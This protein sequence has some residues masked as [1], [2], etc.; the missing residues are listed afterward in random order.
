[1]LITRNLSRRRLRVKRLS[2]KYCCR[3]RLCHLPEYRM[4]D[5][6]HESLCRTGLKYDALKELVAILPP[7]CF[8]FLRFIILKE[9]ELKIIYQFKEGI[10]LYSLRHI[11]IRKLIV[12]I[13]V[14]H[15]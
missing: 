2:M 15:V 11:R 4:H 10:V 7:D 9:N 6:K 12:F 14:R 5:E 13:I 8:I 1:M 3:H